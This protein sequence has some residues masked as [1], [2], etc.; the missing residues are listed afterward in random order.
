MMTMNQK[1]AVGE[2]AILWMPDISCHRQEVMITGFA[3]K[4]YRTDGY[5]GPLYTI[6]FPSGRCRTKDGR[7]MAAAPHELRKRKPPAPPLDFSAGSWDACPFKP[8]K[9]EV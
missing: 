5:V 6:E 8:R 3:L 1:F 9:A 4:D 7:L 2:V